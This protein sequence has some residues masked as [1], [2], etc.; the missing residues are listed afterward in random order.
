MKTESTGTEICITHVNLQDL[1][2]LEPSEVTKEELRR[3][4]QNWMTPW[5]IIKKI[6]EITQ[7]SFELDVCA[8]EES[9]KA[10]KYFSLQAGQ[11]ALEERWLASGLIWMNPPF[12]DIHRWV[13]Y[14]HEQSNLNGV[15]VIAL[16][17]NSTDVPFYQKIIQKNN[18]PHVFTKRIKFR[19]TQEMIEGGIKETSPR[20]GHMLVGFCSSMGKYDF[21][22][23]VEFVKFNNGEI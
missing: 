22:K 5:R 23:V 14:A 7:R 16:L 8:D 15:D 13:K 1:N 18:I 9:A 2:G 21:L 19:R 12:D 20:T 6:E 17:P 4:R 11:N 10:D 3:L